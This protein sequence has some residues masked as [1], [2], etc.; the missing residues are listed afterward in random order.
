M[1]RALEPLRAWAGGAWRG[2][3]RFWFTP[4][5]PATLGVIRVL[6]GAMLLY[7]HAIWTL[8]LEGFFGAGGW[9]SPAAME[10]LRRDS[11]AMSY[12]WAIRSPTALWIA[13]GAALVAFALLMVGLFSR[14]A[15]VLSAI[16]ALS[17]AARVPGALF[18]L[19]QINVML[20]VYLAVGPSGD[21]FSLDRLV[22]RRRGRAT[23]AP[24]SG[25]NVAVR[26]I[27]LHMCVIY[28]FSGASKL[29]GP[30]W[31]N[32][33]ALWGAFGN[34]EYQSLDVTWLAGWPRLVAL[35]THVTVFWEL[36]YAALVWPRATRPLVLL[37]AVP[38]H[39][40][41]ALCLGMATFGVV[42]FSGNGAWGP[43]G[44]AGGGRGAPAPRPSP[45]EVVET[46]T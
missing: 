28:F 31:W 42:F 24:S 3:D 6:A 38:V 22:A 43:P 9:S 37:A 23:P 4:S 30:A 27:Q 1:T 39:L 41:I 34:L 15:A 29:M 7:T 33:T 26:L 46:K 19:D 32:G 2:W 14:V 18:G 16:A 44:R 17:Y 36:S 21:A 40:G 8:D 10:L 25:A 5:D 45:R 12:F 13:H 20:A 35:M 11:Y